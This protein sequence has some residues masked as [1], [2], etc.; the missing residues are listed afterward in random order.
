[1]VDPHTMKRGDILAFFEHI[2]KRQQ[3]FDLPQVFRFKTAN[4][5]RKGNKT[6]DEI[7]LDDCNNDLHDADADTGLAPNADMGLAPSA[8]TGLAPSAEAA[9]PAPRPRPK[10]QK[11]KRGNDGMALDNRI[12]DFDDADAPTCV[13]PSA[14]GAVSRPRPKPKRV[15]Q[16]NATGDTPQDNSQDNSRHHV[17]DAER[18]V[19]LRASA[20]CGQQVTHN[21]T[22]FNDELE[23]NPVGWRNPG[24]DYVFP[25]NLLLTPTNLNTL[26]DSTTNVLEAPLQPTKPPKKAKKANAKKKTKERDELDADDLDADPV[27]RP[28]QADRLLIKLPPTRGKQKKNGKLVTP[29]VSAI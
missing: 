2:A 17:D 18:H 23:A 25:D 21:D 20:E 9:V 14:K 29:T 8:D 26:G 6:L 22:G 28:E 24:Q 4:V 10:K 27:Q 15:T 11:K 3:T 16:R 1:M 13:A 19:R 12:E 7:T 5:G